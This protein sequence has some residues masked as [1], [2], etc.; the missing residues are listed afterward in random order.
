[1]DVLY[2]TYSNLDEGLVFPNELEEGIYSPGMWMIQGNSISTCPSILS[3]DAVF[4]NQLQKLTLRR[5]EG[6]YYQ[7]DTKKFGKVNFRL[8]EL[9][10]RYQN[11]VGKSQFINRD[12]KFFQ[13][14]PI[15]IPK[16]TELCLK[17]HFFFIGKIDEEIRKE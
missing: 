16:I 5:I 12:L 8:I 10:R 1:M 2:L 15:D 14:V 6:N 3:F 17:N 9:Y 4:E 11:Y 7:S 13:L